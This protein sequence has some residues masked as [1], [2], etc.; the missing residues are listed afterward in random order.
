M[1]VV[2]APTEGEG[3]GVI[4]TISLGGGWMVD[5]F[6]FFWVD[7]LQVTQS[8]LLVAVIYSHYGAF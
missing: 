4:L 2:D 5:P 3:G 1:D 6:F 7:P 8:S